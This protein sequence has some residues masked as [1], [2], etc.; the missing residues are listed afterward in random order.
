MSDPVKLVV[1][2]DPGQ[3]GKLE[4]RIVERV[5]ERMRAAEIE[6]LLTVSEVAQMFGVDEVWVRRHQRELGG[7]K[8][9][10]GAGRS[11]LR[12]RAS[13]VE[14]FLSRHQLKTPTTAR[15][16]REDERWALP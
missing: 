6:K 9:S 15:S 4:D 7:Y 5:L 10:E 1:T 8:L 13:V 12:F 14:K 16:W 3:L 11:P 2:I